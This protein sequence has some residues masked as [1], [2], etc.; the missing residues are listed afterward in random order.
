M[1][2]QAL[3]TDSGDQGDELSKVTAI[4]LEFRDLCAGD[5]SRELG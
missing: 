4:E 1:V 2:F 5:G 3:I